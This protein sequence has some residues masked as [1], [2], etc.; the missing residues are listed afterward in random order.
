VIKYLLDTNVISELRKP[1]PHGGVTAWVQAL[2]WKQLFLSAVTLGE[3]QAGIELTRQQDPSKAGQIEAW[4]NRL[5][6]S[7]QVLP[8]DGDCFR[9]CAR[10]MHGQPDDLLLDGM[11]AAT[12]SVHDLTVATRNT[13]DF[14]RLGV[15]VVDPFR[16][17]R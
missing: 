6:G 4:V 8:M 16:V 10:R 14:V 17:A 1:R 2:D 15:Q 5:A 11:I 9:E 13:R 3:L 12:A 7:F